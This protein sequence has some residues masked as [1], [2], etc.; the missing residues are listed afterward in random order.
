[1]PLRVVEIVPVLPLE[2]VEIVP[3]AV[4]E[5]VP[6]LVVEIVPPLAKVMA[7]SV[8]IST[9]AQAMDLKFFIV[10]LLVTGNVRG[11][12][13]ARRFRRQAFPLGRLLTNN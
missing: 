6:V 2:V 4:V 5:M 13:S 12:R 7:E 8:I 11:T 1:M 9:A 3:V 10:L